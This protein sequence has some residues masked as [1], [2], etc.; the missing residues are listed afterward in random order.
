MSLKG[1]SE[2]GRTFAISWAKLSHAYEPQESSDQTN[3][4]FK[5][6]SRI[7]AASSA[8]KYS[9]SAC[10]SITKP[11]R[12]SASSVGRTIRGRG[13]PLG[14]LLTADLVSSD[15]RVLKL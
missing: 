7:R 5:R 14:S 3:P 2:G 12:N 11:H 9:D 15:R 13:S 1:N 8:L 10:H 4:P 6:Y